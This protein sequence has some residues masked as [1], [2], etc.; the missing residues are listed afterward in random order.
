MKKTIMLLTAL[1]ALG[2]A[3]ANS[4]DGVLFVRPSWTYKKTGG[5]S[6]LSQSFDDFL[7]WRHADGTNAYQMQVI[8][9]DTRTL[10]NSQEHIV[11]LASFADG[12]GDTRSFRTVRFLAL[13]TASNNVDAVQLGGAADA[14]FW[15]W[16]AYT[17]DAVV[18]QPGGLALFVAPQLNGYQVGTSTN[19]LLKNTGT[20]SATYYLYVAGNE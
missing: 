2:L 15:S 14:P 5:S 20:N 4:F 19:L 7:Q 18:V 13:Q 8:C 3:A 17:N 11:S 6:T 1:A 16:A 10:T 9:V 12:F